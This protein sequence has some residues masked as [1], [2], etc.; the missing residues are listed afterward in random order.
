MQPADGDVIRRP[1]I[2]ASAQELA[3]KCW[4]ED[5]AFLKRDKI[6]E[7]LGGLGL[8]KP[9]ARG[10]YFANFDFGGLRLDVAFRKL[11][12]KL[13][14]R[15]ETQQIDRILAAFSQRYYE[16]NPESV[17]GSAD[18]VHS[19]VF[20]ILLLNTDLH[21][22]ELQERMTRQQFVRNTLGAIAE[23][24]QKAHPSQL[25]TAMIAGAASATFRTTL[26]AAP[27][28]SLRARQPT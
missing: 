20:S 23:S 19:V 18:V 3:T 8:V 22:A 11:C 6:A 13:F 9:R 5:P 17:F 24:S 14:L 4:H 26:H 27:M 28:P 1:S 15:A 10:Y 16:C 12:D 25:S 2:A 21:I 7:W